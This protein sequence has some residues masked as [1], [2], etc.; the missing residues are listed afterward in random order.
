LREFHL[1]LLYF[2]ACLFPVAVYC[3]FLG[4]IHRRS[5][6]LMVAGPWDLVGVLF[7]ASGFLLVAFPTVL[8]RVYDKARH[9]LAGA[10]Q[11]RRLTS[12]L[13]D[14]LSYYPLL[15]ALYYVLL[16]G[17]GALLLWARRRKTVVYNVDPP[18]LDAT[19]AGSLDRLGL[20]WS[21]QGNRLNLNPVTE[22]VVRP[23]SDAITLRP[24]AVVRPPALVTEEAALVVVEPFEMMANVTLHWRACPP[25]VREE[26][27]AEIGKAL[28]QVRVEDNPAGTWMLGISGFLF[29]LMFLTAAI[30]LLALFLGQ[31]R[32]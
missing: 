4:A 20:T 8:V 14:V 6:P 15:T 23:A 9:Q 7:A 5:R 12:A 21:R 24:A 30:L 16:L 28:A 31:R 10:P 2:L 19:L 13:W 1:F 27:E 29:G 17:G 26:V 25:Q 32:P 18:T 22:P 3:W 11:G